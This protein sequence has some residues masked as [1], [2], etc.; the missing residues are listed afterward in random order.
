M[1]F[2]NI[3]AFKSPPTHFKV[4]RDG[5]F[6]KDH[7]DKLPSMVCEMLESLK[8]KYCSEPWFIKAWNEYRTYVF[9]TPID[10]LRTPGYIFKK[11]VDV[12]KRPEPE[13]IKHYGIKGQKWGV[14]RF[15]NED[16]SLIHPSGKKF[17]TDRDK[18][19]LAK[20]VAIGLGAAAITAGVAY[21]GTKYMKN[22][23]AKKAANFILSPV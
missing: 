13:V 16:G 1:S 21:M 9:R 20:K 19:D 22:I 5:G 10:K 3:N 8:Q 11:Y 7:Y 2:G 18:S 15:Q 17:R 23:R 12:D 14:R 4:V 6:K